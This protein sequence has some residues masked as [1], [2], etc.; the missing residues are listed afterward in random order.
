MMEWVPRWISTVRMLLR[1]R[2]DLLLEFIVV[3]HQLAVLQRTGTRHP[4]FCPNELL[5]WMFLSRWWANWQRSLIIVQPA[6][7]LRWRRRGFWA[8]LV[9]GSCG[10]WRG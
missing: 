3:H 5:F 7:V 4:C 1:R 6:T 10:R 2:L 9:S 8:I